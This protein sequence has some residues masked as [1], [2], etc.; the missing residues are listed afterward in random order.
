MLLAQICL[1]DD[2][3]ASWKL[4]WFLIS[5]RS[6]QATQINYLFFSRWRL[7]NLS[8]AKQTVAVLIIQTWFYRL[9]ICL[10]RNPFGIN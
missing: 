7:N 3:E 5:G 2:E 6:E 1:P 10:A 8:N 4:A 9:H